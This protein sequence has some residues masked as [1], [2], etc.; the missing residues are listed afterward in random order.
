[1]NIALYSKVLDKYK[2]LG[3]IDKILKYINEENRRPRYDTP[4]TQSMRNVIDISIAVCA[5]VTLCIVL[6][7]AVHN[8][9]QTNAGERLHN[10]A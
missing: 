3:E 5:I 4:D 9:H 6:L 1:M 8:K 7:I 2:I 10:W